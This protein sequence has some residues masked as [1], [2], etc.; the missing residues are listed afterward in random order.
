MVVKLMSYLYEIKTDRKGEKFV[1]I[2]GYEG[3]IRSLNIPEFIEEIPVKKVGANAFSGREDIRTLSLPKTIDTL[4]RYAF[5]NCK[6]LEEITLF[7]SVEDY[8]DGVVKQCRSLKYIRLYQERE[9]Y[10]V[11]KEILA[12]Y[13]RCLHFIV[14]PAELHLTFP[15]YVYD[16]VEDVEARVL[17]HKIT[18]SGYP[19]RECVTR[20]GVDLLSYDRIFSQVIADDHRA[21]IDIAFDRLLH[22]VELENSAR[23]RYEQYLET[24]GKVVTEF[25]IESDRVEELIYMTEA[26]LIKREVLDFAIELSAQQKKSEI[27]ALLMEYQRKHFTAKTKAQTFSLEDW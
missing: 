18:G 17:H 11:M 13:D 27:T 1:E 2:T 9:S 23:E 20:K 10:S 12:D 7:D 6:N 21:A 8:Y 25:L 16:F 4:G 26:C 15:A 22:P 14:E 3:R 5:Y 19:Y 24:T